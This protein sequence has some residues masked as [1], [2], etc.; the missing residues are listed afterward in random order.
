[1]KF[2]V[3]TLAAAGEFRRDLQHELTHDGPRAAET[4]SGRTAFASASVASASASAFD[5]GAGAVRA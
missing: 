3:R 4:V 2:T 1:M 5:L